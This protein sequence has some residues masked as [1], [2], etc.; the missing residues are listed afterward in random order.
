MPKSLMTEEKV[1]T[2]E[3]LCRMKPT[4]VDCAEILGVNPS[5]IER[6]IR[7]HHK[8]TFAEFRNQKL[9]WTRHMVIRN[10][11]KQCENGNLTALIYVSK[12]L[13]G[14]SDKPED[15]DDENQVQVIVNGKKS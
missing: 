3:K 7:K 11:L 5:T 13:C 4:L 9:A 12:N 2:L 8:C 6:W 1:R 10:L 15:Q 14:W